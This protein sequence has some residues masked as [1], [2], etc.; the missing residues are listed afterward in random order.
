LQNVILV[1]SLEKEL[2]L[3]EVFVPPAPGNAGCALGAGLLVWHHFMK[4]PRGKVFPM[5]TGDRLT[6]AM[7]FGHIGRKFKSAVLFIKY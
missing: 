7:K 2:G 1:A 6:S 4:N 5:C 3:N